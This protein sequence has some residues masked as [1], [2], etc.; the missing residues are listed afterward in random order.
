MCIQQVCVPTLHLCRFPQVQFIYQD[1]SRNFDRNRVKG[2][3]A[4]LVRVNDVSAATALEV[5]AGSKVCACDGHMI[6]PHDL[7]AC[8]YASSQDRDLYFKN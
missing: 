7:R 1:P 8:K 2:P 3:V 5:T 6:W 4:K